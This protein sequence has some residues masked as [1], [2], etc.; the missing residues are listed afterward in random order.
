MLI[1]T[2]YNNG[3]GVGLGLCQVHIILY[4]PSPLVCIELLERVF[5][6]LGVAESDEQLQQCLTRFLVP[7]ILKSISPHQTVK[8]KVHH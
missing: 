5:L 3:L 2:V 1:Y 8:D 6:R 4:S 7:T